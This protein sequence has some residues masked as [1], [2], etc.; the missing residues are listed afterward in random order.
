MSFHPCIYGKN[1]RS[2]LPNCCIIC[3]RTSCYLW[4]DVWSIWTL[5]CRHPLSEDKTLSLTS[6]NLPLMLKSLKGSLSH[7]FYINPP[8]GLGAGIYG[9]SLGFLCDS[10]KANSHFR[11]YYTNTSTDTSVFLYIH[12]IHCIWWLKLHSKNSWG[13]LNLNSCVMPTSNGAC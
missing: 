9:Y 2:S 8:S 3:S 7:R 5:V 6:A 11:I 13:N 4:I 1:P 10:L 12:A